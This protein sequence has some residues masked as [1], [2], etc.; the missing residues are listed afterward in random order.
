MLAQIVIRSNGMILLLL[1]IASMLL[2]WYRGQLSWFEALFQSV[3]MEIGTWYVIIMAFFLYR[4]G[5]VGISIFFAW[6][7]LH[8]IIY[9]HQKK[10]GKALSIGLIISF[11]V[12]GVAILL[13]ELNFTNTQIYH[14]SKI[15]LLPTLGLF[16]IR[17]F[18]YLVIYPGIHK[19]EISLTFCLISN[20]VIAIIFFTLM[21]PVIR[22]PYKN[23]LFTDPVEE[24]LMEGNIKSALD[25]QRVERS[26]PQYLVGFTDYNKP[27]EIYSAEELRHL[28]SCNRHEPSRGFIILAE[29]ALTVPTL[30]DEARSELEVWKSYY[31]Y[32]YAAYDAIVVGDQDSLNRIYQDWV[33]L[34]L[35]QSEN[36]RP[37]PDAAIRNLIGQC[38]SYLYIPRLPAE[39]DDSEPNTDDDR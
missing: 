35:P 7:V 16:F 30:T 6:A 8:T 34:E 11:V 28:M 1:I 23:V 10:I 5:K 17:I 15:L 32:Y 24:S 12:F 20:I 27:P 9:N 3:Y 36:P 33:K 4:F 31:E 22:N 13:L 18:F 25:Y 19:R 2:I 39:T 29:D 37:S 14:F 26:S 21:G 38:K